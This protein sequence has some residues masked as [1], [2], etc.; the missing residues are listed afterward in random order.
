MRTTVVKFAAT[1]ENAEDGDLGSVREV[2]EWN[3]RFHDSVVAAARHQRLA[4]MLRVTVDATLVFRS[5]RRFNHAEFVRSDQ[6]H[7]LIFH[8]ISDHDGQ[9]ASRLMQEHIDQGRDVL[10]RG[11]DVRD[12]RRDGADRL[13]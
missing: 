5:F 6:F 8:A 4:E 9:R 10:L 12:V 11:V 2:A 1:V 3:R 13:E 7:R